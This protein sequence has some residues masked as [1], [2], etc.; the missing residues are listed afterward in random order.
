MELLAM[1]F[2]GLG[3]SMDS[4]ALS[5][6]CGLQQTTEKMKTAMK[7]AVIFAISQ[8]T[9]PLIGFL[10]GA[11]FAD[12]IVKYD[13]WIALVLLALIGGNMIRE[14]IKTRN[15]PESCEDRKLT[16]WVLITMGIATSIDALAAGVTLA[17]IS[18]NI[19]LALLTIFLATL[20]VSL[21]GY[22][23][24]EKVGK[25]FQSWAELFGGVV[26]AGLGIQIFVEHMW[27]A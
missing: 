8:T 19:W 12:E 4:L 10:A 9:T 14:G 17:F 22:M 25:L 15:D 26:L 23:V 24:G 21:I 7:V 11:A 3:L 6:S 2:L 1:I 18:V 5:L 13:H 27:L 20:I 16:V